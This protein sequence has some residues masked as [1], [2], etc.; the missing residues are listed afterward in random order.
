MSMDDM[1]PPF[2][3]PANELTAR[4]VVSS[5]L[6]D[7]DYASAAFG[8]VDRQS[9]PDLGYRWFAASLG[10]ASYSMAPY[11]SM[12]PLPDLSAP[13]LPSGQDSSD[14]GAVPSMQ[15]MMAQEAKRQHPWPQLDSGSAAGGDSG[16]AAR[17]ARRARDEDGMADLM[18]EGVESGGKR[19]KRTAGQPHTQQ[20][21][22]STES[23]EHASAAPSSVGSAAGS[24]ASQAGDNGEPPIVDDKRREWNRL[25]ARKSRIRKKFL[26]EN[27]V[28]RLEELRTQNRNIRTMIARG[29]MTEAWTSWSQ[30]HAPDMTHP[31]TASGMSAEE[32]A[33]ASGIAL[34]TLPPIAAAAAA[35]S[36]RALVVEGSLDPAVA[37]TS[38]LPGGKGLTPGPTPDKPLLR[39]LVAPSGGG[40]GPPPS[41]SSSSSDYTGSQVLHDT[42][43]A[44]ISSIN[45][46]KRHFLI[47]DPLAPDNPI[48]FASQGFFDLTGYRPDEVL[49]RNCRFLQ[50]PQTDPRAVDDI[51]RAVHEGRDCHAVLLNY[52]K[53]GTQFWNDFFLAPL[54]DPTGRVVHFV[55]V[56]CATTPSRA[57]EL[58]RL[59]EAVKVSRDPEAARAL[60]AIEEGM[61]ATQTAVGRAVVA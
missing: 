31:S 1:L 42:D 48:V 60:R 3:R 21:P 25:N 37:A 58:L 26:V 50:G 9:A 6:D 23:S 47:T 5:Y 33:A 57:S 39:P 43:Y 46:T 41:S 59:Q 10:S 17:A 40:G 51:R 8:P 14:G 45:A 27:M 34:H 61:S 15:Q 53:D 16:A 30:T 32:I 7:G 19:P 56:Q 11:N 2:F 18:A 54:R 49:G 13:L 22:A 55:G 35:G 12:P 4:D 29:G 52:R 24:T 36:A 20:R 44:L 38:T 28:T